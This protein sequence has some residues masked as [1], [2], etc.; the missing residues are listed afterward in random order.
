VVALEI[1][2]PACLNGFFIA[3]TLVYILGI[4]N[5]EVFILKA[6][7]I[8]SAKLFILKPKFCIEGI[9]IPPSATITP[10]C[11]FFGV[12]AVL[13]SAAAFNLS[14]VDDGSCFLTHCPA[15]F[16]GVGIKSNS[17]YGLVPVKLYCTT[18]F[19]RS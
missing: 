13:F 5:V 1:A 14:D 10:P 9:F 16:N 19:L 2:S 12:Y 15:F 17:L 4:L 11:L 3:D 18:A 6:P 7:A 8:L